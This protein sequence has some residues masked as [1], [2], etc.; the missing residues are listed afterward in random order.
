M[1]VA[2]QLRV[3]L[4]IT[5]LVQGVCYRASARDRAIDL[6][7]TGWVKNNLDGSVEALAEGPIAAV[8]QFIDWCRRGPPDAEVADVTTAR[9]AATGEYGR[10]IIA[11]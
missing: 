9:G 8:E 10:F 6:G 4:H 2:S 1:S 5:G 3:Q 7:L 11:R